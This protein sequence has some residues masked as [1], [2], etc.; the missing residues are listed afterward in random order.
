MELNGYHQANDHCS[1]LDQKFR[2][3]GAQTA[4]CGHQSVAG[5]AVVHIQ[6]VVVDEQLDVVSFAV[7]E[8]DTLGGSN[9]SSRHLACHAVD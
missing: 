7:V 9:L 4:C 3:S 2:Q 5:A 1:D 8:S 6:C